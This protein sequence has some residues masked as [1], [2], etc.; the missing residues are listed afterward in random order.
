MRIKGGRTGGRGREGRDERRGTNS[1]E[2]EAF[3]PHRDLVI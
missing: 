3:L 1:E 2:E